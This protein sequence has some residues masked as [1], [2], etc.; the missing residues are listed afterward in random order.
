MVNSGIDNSPNGATEDSMFYRPPG[1][2]Y[3][4]ARIAGLRAVLAL[5][6]CVLSLVAGYHVS[7]A[8]ERMA[9]ARQTYQGG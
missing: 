3:H 7:S 4:R 2:A 5:I 1:S 9:H 6:L 8:V